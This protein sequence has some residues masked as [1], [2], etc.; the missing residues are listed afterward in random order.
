MKQILAIIIIGFAC[1]LSA[2]DIT[3]KLTEEQ[4]AAVNAVV[5]AENITIAAYNVNT[6]NVVKL[7]PV[8]A[9]DVLARY[10]SRLVAIQG[11]NRTSAVV[12]K[13]AKA[14]EADKVKI[15]AEIAKIPDA[16]EPVEVPK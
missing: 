15:E 9:S 2:A 4:E 7:T 14:S 11:Q 8:T 5:T 6:N 3:V 16:V 12:A 10:A 1:S 13:F